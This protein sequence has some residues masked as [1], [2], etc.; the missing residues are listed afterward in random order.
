[1]DVVR[2]GVILFTENYDACVRFYSDVM[3]LQV[4]EV[5]DDAHSKLTR[6]DFGGAYLMIETG[7]TASARMKA[8]DR[9]PVCLR[10]N[11]EDIAAAADEL[12]ARGVTTVVR[13]FPWGSIADFADPDGNRCSFRQV[14]R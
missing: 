10:F 13:H 2:T 8:L 6:L 9:N 4:E 7:G 3:G 14:S 5:L 12:E 1:M 11:V